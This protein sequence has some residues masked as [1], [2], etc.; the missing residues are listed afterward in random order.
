MGMKAGLAIVVVVAALSAVTAAALAST[1]GHQRARLV[2]PASTTAFVGPAGVEQSHQPSFSVPT[3]GT[4]QL[5]SGVTESTNA[6]RVTAL[7]AP[8]YYGTEP[9]TL[10]EARRGSALIVT[11]VPR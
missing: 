2:S 6:V 11:V 4:E 9:A 5:V 7:G 3:G 8:V 1:G 10:S